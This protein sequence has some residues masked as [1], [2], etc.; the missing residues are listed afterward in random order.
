MSPLAKHGGAVHL[1]PFI[2]LSERW[3]CFLVD[4][5]CK[6]IRYSLRRAGRNSGHNLC[7]LANTRPRFGYRRLPSYCGKTVNRRDQ[8]ECI[9]AI[10][11]EP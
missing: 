8:P 9:E 10:A 6:L 7:D 1:Q 5:N 2:G 4:A 3:G 11:K